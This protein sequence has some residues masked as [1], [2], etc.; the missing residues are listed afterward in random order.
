MILNAHEFLV[1][2]FYIFYNLLRKFPETA[3]LCES[4]APW[5]SLTS[6]LWLKMGAPL[7]LTISTPLKMKQVIAFAIKTKKPDYSL[8]VLLQYKTRN[9]SLHKI[10]VAQTGKQ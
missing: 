2:D 9:V 1:P 6:H 8:S 3:P 7:I 5:A 10:N 4:K